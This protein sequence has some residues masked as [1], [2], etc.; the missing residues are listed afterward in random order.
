MRR[1]RIIVG[2]DSYDPVTGELFVPAPV[3]FASSLHYRQ[4]VANMEDRRR[5]VFNVWSPPRA[6]RRSD[7]RIVVRSSKV[8]GR[9][10]FSGLKFSVPERVALCAKRKIR[11]EIMFARGHGGQ[12]GA[13]RSYRRNRFSGIGC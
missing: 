2:G 10:T 4:L 3:H 12:G 8:L 13:K 11:R 1:S 7:A 6:V 9:A 5:H